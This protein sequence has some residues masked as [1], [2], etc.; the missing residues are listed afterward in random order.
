LQALLVTASLKGDGP[1]NYKLQVAS[2]KLQASSFKLQAGKKDLTMV[3]GQYRMYLL[4]E[5]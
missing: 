4:T 2:F 1:T 3:I 5:R